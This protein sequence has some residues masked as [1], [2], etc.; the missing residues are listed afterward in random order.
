MGSR[1]RGDMGGCEA[2]TQGALVSIADTG[3]TE[4]AVSRRTGRPGGSDLHC[5]VAS[6]YGG[7]RRYCL[8]ASQRASG[9]TAGISPNPSFGRLPGG[10]CRPGARVGR[11]IRAGASPARRRW[12]PGSSDPRMRRPARRRCRARSP[13]CRTRRRRSSGRTR[14]F[15]ARPCRRSGR[16][17]CVAPQSGCPR[18]ETVPGRRTRFLTAAGRRGSGRR[19]AEWARRRR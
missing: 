2:R 14:T 5:V 17:P 3:A 10:D 6:Q 15:A 7:G 1:R 9:A 13:F 12:A 18:H 8:G 16:S 11:P 4:D 19:R